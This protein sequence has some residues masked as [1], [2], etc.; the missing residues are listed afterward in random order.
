MSSVEAIL[1]S[2]VKSALLRHDHP[3]AIWL[4]ERLC[5]TVSAADSVGA[6]SAR[7]LLATCHYHSGKPNRVY[8]LLK[9]VSDAESRYLFA[10][11]CYELQKFHEGEM[12]LLGATAS[13]L[14]E[15]SVEAVPGAEGFHLLGLICQRLS[16]RDQAIA[17]FKRSLS[18]D[19]F[20]WASF[21]ALCELGAEVDCETM[22]RASP[23]TL[24]PAGESPPSVILS[25]PRHEIEG[26]VTPL[27][28]RPNTRRSGRLSMPSATTTDN[29]IKKRNKSRLSVSGGGDMSHLVT[30]A[31]S[32]R[33]TTLTHKTSLTTPAENPSTPERKG[34]K[35]H[36]PAPQKQR[37]KKI[38]DSHGHGVHALGDAT[39]LSPERPIITPSTGAKTR[40]VRARTGRQGPRF[41][42]LK[43]VESDTT[44][45]PD[46]DSPTPIISISEATP[47]HSIP[48]LEIKTSQNVSFVDLRRLATAFALQCDYKCK[49]AIEV[50]QIVS[51]RHLESAW[52]LAQLGRCY[53][54]LV[55]Y[56]KS[57]AM[58]QRA[59]RLEPCRMTG[60]EF[61]STALWHLKKEVELSFLAQQVLE[62]DKLSAEAWIVVGNCF[63]LQKDHETALK[64]FRRASQLNPYMAY[65]Y[66]LSAHEC[67]ANEDFEKAQAGYR[68]AIGVDERH[69]NAWYGMGNIYWRQEKCELASYHFKRALS[70][71][72]R[73]SVLYSHYAIALHA[74]KRSEEALEKLQTAIELEPANFQAKYQ[75]ANIY[76]ALER[77]DEALGELEAILERAPKEASVH[78]LIGKIYKKLKQTDQAMKHFV[79]ALDL[80]PRDRNLIKATIDKLH[81]GEGKQQSDDDL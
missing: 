35:G 18:L 56:P 25:P 78:M 24:P 65:A 64:F 47:R 59:T 3:T 1:T 48:P 67:L 8:W 11:S 20:L 53:F 40:L 13:T 23:P 31:P 80:D 37:P 16:R 39:Y 62:Y 19:S 73:S 38:P 2:K 4:C 68:H 51:Q 76:F 14:S 79:I 9:G 81:A 32:S 12:A 77:Y 57:I 61:Y 66:T 21:Q 10:L 69:Y 46:S 43:S 70:I 36:G 22:F 30:P 74:C 45:T 50:Y 44:R 60:L 72:T 63:S 17:H 33:R 29:F 58:F 54:D 75:T 26:F 5:A 28:A 42:L 27:Q 15:G 41:N 52:V 34:N 7:L 55:D 49:E 6:M 71:N